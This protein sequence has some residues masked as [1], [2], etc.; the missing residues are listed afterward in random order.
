VLAI[1]AKAKN[2]EAARQFINFLLRPEIV[3]DIT[4]WTGAANPNLLA[5]DFVDDDDKGDETV[6]PSPTSWARLFLDR[7]HAGDVDKA[8]ARIWAR[9]KP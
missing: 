7:P 1:P 8:R 3:S 5:A 9:S 2:V 4:D 6:F